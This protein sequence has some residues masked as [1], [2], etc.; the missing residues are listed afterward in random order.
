MQS[1]HEREL[2]QAMC[3]VMVGGTKSKESKEPVENAFAVLGQDDAGTAQ[4]CGKY[5]TGGR[6]GGR[7]GGRPPR[8]EGCFDCGEAG[9]Y[10]GSDDCARPSYR[11]LRDRERAQGRVAMAV[12][13]GAWTVVISAPVA[14]VGSRTGPIAMMDS[15]CSDVL[16]GDQTIF[17]NY[18][19]LDHAERKIYT[20]AHESDIISD[21][22]I[23]DVYAYS[24]V[25]GDM[26]LVKFSNV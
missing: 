22:E 20:I 11:V 18:R 2:A 13:P 1:Q 23:G 12:P 7:G 16:T 9:H 19:E 5:K 25:G 10:R 26:V 14:M 17:A 6:S 8:E 24:P 4:G 21:V 15:G 3:K